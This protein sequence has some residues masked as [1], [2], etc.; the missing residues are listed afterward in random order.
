MSAYD[1][2][3]AGELTD[4]VYE[5]ETGATVPDLVEAEREAVTA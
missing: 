2:Y 5:P 4:V 3:L 1:A